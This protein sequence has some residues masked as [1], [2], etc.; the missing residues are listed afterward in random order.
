MR[1]WTELPDEFISVVGRSDSRAY[2]LQIAGC[3]G[4]LLLPHEFP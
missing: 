4:F 1:L 3:T 2:N